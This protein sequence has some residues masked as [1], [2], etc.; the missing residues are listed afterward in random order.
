MM[1]A[2]EPVVAC[3]WLEWASRQTYGCDD[4]VFQANLVSNEPLFQNLSLVVSSFGSK[5]VEK[6]EGPGMVVD[7]SR[8]AKTPPPCPWAFWAT[9]LLCETHS[10]IAA[11]LS[12][13]F[14]L[15]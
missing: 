8:C 15:L 1:L 10:D 12:A 6:S 4:T 3:G 13:I 9:G 7:M 2:Q 14:G 11:C 5:A